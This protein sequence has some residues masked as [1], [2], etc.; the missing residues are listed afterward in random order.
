MNK[1]QLIQTITQALQDKIHTL[2]ESSQKTRAV[3]NDEQNKSEGKYD[4]RST[5]ENYL[6]DGFARQALVATETLAAFKGMQIKG[7]TDNT[8][9]E[10]SALIQVNIAQ[11]LFWFLLAPVAGGLEVTHEGNEVTVLSLDSPLGSQLNGLKVGD[12]IQSPQAKILSV[13]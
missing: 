8:P 1:E 5:E 10:T 3:G 11:E 2:H 6:A 13:Q 4:T 7:F 9:I 12:Q